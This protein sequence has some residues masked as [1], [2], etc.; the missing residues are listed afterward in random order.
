MFSAPFS[1]SSVPGSC[2]LLFFSPSRTLIVYLSLPS[3]IGEEEGEREVE[4]DDDYGEEEEEEE[5]KDTSWKEKEKKRSWFASAF[6]FSNSLVRQSEC[7]SSRNVQLATSKWVTL[8]QLRLSSSVLCL[9]DCCYTVS[10]TISLTISILPFSILSV[11]SCIWL[12]STLFNSIQVQCI[13]YFLSTRSSSCFFHHFSNPF[14]HLFLIYFTKSRRNAFYSPPYVVTELSGWR[15]LYKLPY[16]HP[17]LNSLAAILPLFP[18]NPFFRV[19]T[20]L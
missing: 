17:R 7:L 5:E 6:P 2:L 11:W 13:L 18:F 10:V 15:L 3:Q 20:C 4:D 9:S 8:D 19:S 14:L 12:D 16:P 1:T